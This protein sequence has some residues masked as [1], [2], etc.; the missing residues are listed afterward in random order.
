MHHDQIWAP[1]RPA[2]VQGDA[3]KQTRP[4]PTLKLLGDADEECFLCHDVADTSDRENLV[5]HRAEHC[6]TVLNRFPY[7]NGHLLVAPQ[8]HQGDPSELGDEETPI[9]RPLSKFRPDDPRDD[10]NSVPTRRARFSSQRIVLHC[11]DPER[12]RDAGCLKPTDCIT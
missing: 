5:I 4:E 1:W 12:L 3:S 10:T 2:Y 7:N 11:R 6:L 8:R 9:Q